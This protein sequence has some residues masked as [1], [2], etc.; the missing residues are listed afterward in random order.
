MDAATV[1]TNVTELSASF[2]ADRRA[3]QMRRHLEPAD[4]EALAKAGYL[5]T[6]VPVGMGGLWTDLQTSTR[7]I[8]EILRSIARGDPSVA[9]V[10]AMHP[11]VLSFWLGVPEAPE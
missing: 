3:R 10:S 1:L 4:F 9:L 8:S 5:L 2:S 11:A 7:P 6:G